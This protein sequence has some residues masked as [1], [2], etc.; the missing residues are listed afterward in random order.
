MRYWLMKTEPDVFSWDDLERCPNRTTMWEGVRNYQ[1]RNFMR[2]EFGVGDGVL[3]YHSR[4]NPSV[5]GV[6]RVVRAA[7][8]DP[9]QFVETSRYFDPRSAPD[10]PRWVTVDVQ[11]ERRFP[12]PLTLS[13]LRAER[14]VAGM[15]LL[16]P[17]SRLSVQPVRPHEWE[18]VCR[19]AGVTVD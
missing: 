17:G 7:Y 9:T 6:A 2:D 18:E 3:F 4:K 12:E 5:V 8:P 19:L 15:A 10:A 13:R 1:A 11:A 14:G 16:A